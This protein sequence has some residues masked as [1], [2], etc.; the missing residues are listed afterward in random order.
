MIIDIE[1]KKSR[2]AIVKNSKIVL[3]NDDVLLY[4]VISNHKLSDFILIVENGKLKKEIKAKDGY[5]EIPKELIFAGSLH[6]RI[7]LFGENVLVKDW[8]I[9]PI[10]LTEIDGEILPIPEIEFLRQEVTDL[11]AR[12]EKLEKE[13]EKKDNVKKLFSRK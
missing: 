9:E 3:T 1:L 8:L 11:K 5:F 4:N 6:S 10:I 12:L 7:C 2:L 13:Q